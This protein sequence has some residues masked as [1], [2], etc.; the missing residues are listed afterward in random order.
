MAKPMKQNIAANSSSGATVGYEA[1][2]KKNGKFRDRAA[3]HCVLH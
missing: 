1:Q 2:L 3:T